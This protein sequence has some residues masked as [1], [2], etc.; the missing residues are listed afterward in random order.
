MKIS[1]NL[2][3]A[4]FALSLIISCKN[5]PEGEAATTGEASQTIAKPSTDAKVY[6]VTNGNVYWAATKVGGAHNGAFQI[7]SGKLASENGKVTS[8]VIEIDIKSMSEVT[9]DDGMKAK[10]M[11]HMKSP[12]FFD[13]ENHP[14]GEFTIVSVEPLSGNPEA[15][16]TIKG[17]LMLKGI[18]KSI[19]FPANI[20]VMEDKISVV[21]PKFTINRTEWDMKYNAAIIGT[22]ADKI[23]HDDVSLNIQLEATAR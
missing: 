16:S 3:I 14:N 11:S 10:F 9:L 12:D 23:I 5:Q 1:S 17:N 6:G 22:A 2:L 19:S 21:S 15:N 18:T 20:V 8:G 4:F 7:G 13:A